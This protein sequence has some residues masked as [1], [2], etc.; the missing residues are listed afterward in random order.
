VLSPKAQDPAYFV[1]HQLMTRAPSACR[2]SFAPR[3][4]TTTRR[5]RSSSAA[6]SPTPTSA[7]R[8]ERW[9][10]RWCRRRSGSRACRTT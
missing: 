8:C 4:P 3:P 10:M 2:S 6:S 1:I 9:R 5:A 7:V